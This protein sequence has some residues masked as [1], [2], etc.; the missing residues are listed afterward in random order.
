MTNFDEF[1]PYVDENFIRFPLAEEG[2]YSPTL[3]LWRVFDT[4]E[5]M[6]SFLENKFETDDVSVAIDVREVVGLSKEFVD[7]LPEEVIK[8]LP[9]GSVG[10][11]TYHLEIQV[12]SKLEYDTDLTKLYDVA[13][14]IVKS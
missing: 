4:I 1:I 14:K 12:Y 5:E 11:I 3:N 6:E 13:L 9:E 8:L 10:K 7:S 2:D